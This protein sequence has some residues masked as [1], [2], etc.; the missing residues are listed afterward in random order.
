MI[1]IVKS[2]KGSSII[3]VLILLFV[4]GGLTAALLSASTHNIRFGVSE[5]DTSRAFYFAEA[6]VEYT[7]SFLSRSENSTNDFPQSSQENEIINF[8]VDYEDGIFESTGTVN[9]GTLHEI[10]QIIEFKGDSFLKD[11]AVLGSNTHHDSIDDFAWFRGQEDEFG[12]ENIELVDLGTWEEFL[13]DYG[14][15]IGSGGIVFPPDSFDVENGGIEEDEID[16]YYKEFGHDDWFGEDGEKLWETKDMSRINDDI[17]DSF[18]YLTNE[19]VEVGDEDW[20]EWKKDYIEDYEVGDQVYYYNEDEFRYFEAVQEYYPED[21]GEYFD[22]DG[23]PTDTY[24]DEYWDE[25]E[26]DDGN[27]E[28][29]GGVSIEKS[30]VVIDGSTKMLGNLT[31]RNSLILVKENVEIGGNL[32]LDESLI[33]TFSEED[34]ALITTGNP[35]IGLTLL[36]TPTNWPGIDDLL[37]EIDDAR[38]EFV[39]ESWRQTK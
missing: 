36:S 26:V 8:T 32:D 33:I 37:K 10:T 14:I 35:S 27:L 30:L 25:I 7:K 13:K 29:G 23:N 9:E 18:Y 6:G 22:E 24:W 4:V 19:F 38:F 21:D 12:E 11:V 17:E 15:L 34:D 1:G 39:L 28:F 20:K 5:V 3:W 2:E 16:E 31:L